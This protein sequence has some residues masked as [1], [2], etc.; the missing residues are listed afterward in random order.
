MIRKIINCSHHP[1]STILRVLRY[2]RYKPQFKSYHWSDT[3]TDSRLLTPSCISMGEKVY[4]GSGCKI[5]GIHSYNNMTF[6]PEIVLGDRVVIVHNMYL[7]CA[8]RIEIGSNTSIA[9]NVTITDIIHPYA[10]I[11]TPIERQD[12]TTKEVSIGPD[13]KIY[14]NVVILPGCTIGRHCVIGANSVVNLDM[15]DFTVAVGAPARIIKRYN[16]R[17]GAWQATDRYGNFNDETK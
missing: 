11:S 6:T 15:P 8:S 16:T 13:C 3:V 1:C 7:T 14:N 12:I 17:T 2:L 9:A 5:Q 4:I 10:D